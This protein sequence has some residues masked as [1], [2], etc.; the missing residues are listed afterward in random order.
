MKRI[1]SWR[2]L[3]LSLA[4]CALLA[5]PI[6]EAGHH[7]DASAADTPCPICQLVAHHPVDLLPAAAGV[8]AAALF[9]L[10]FLAPFRAIFRIAL[11]PRL[12]YDSRAPPRLPLPLK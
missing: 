2:L 6:L 1:P 8:G 5:L 9:L 4:C 10:F 7:H 11:A 12:S 3:L